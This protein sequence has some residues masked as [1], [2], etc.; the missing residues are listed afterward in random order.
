MPISLRLTVTAAFSVYHSHAAVED[1]FHNREYATALSLL[2]RAIGLDP[3]N[4]QY[5]VKRADAYL[6][7]G[8]PSSTTTNLQ[9]A[10]TLL[11]PGTCKDAILQQLSLALYL[12]GEALF[13]EGMPHLALEK[14]RSLCALDPSCL[15]PRLKCMACLHGLGQHGECLSE[16]EAALQEHPSNADLFAVRARVHWELGKVSYMPTIQ[17]KQQMS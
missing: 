13:R 8:D 10:L 1:A 2:T 15:V 11:P 7:L 3:H 16:V 14:F 5:F 17:P 6:H 9:H 4:S 12:N